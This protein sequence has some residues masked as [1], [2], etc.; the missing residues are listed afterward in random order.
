MAATRRQTA[1]FRSIVT[2]STDLVIVLGEGG[3]RHVSPSVTGHGRRV[4]RTPILG[5]GLVRFLHPDDRALVRSAHTSGRAEEFVFRI[6]NRFGEWRHL[7][8]H[9]TDLRARPPDPRRS[10]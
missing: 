4:P 5:S 8:A 10:S 3:C 2:A 7:E 6:V 9:V 1:H